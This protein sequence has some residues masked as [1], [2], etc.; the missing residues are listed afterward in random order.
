MPPV[1]FEDLNKVAKGVLIDDYS[2]TYGHEFKAKQKVDS[3]DAVVTTTVTLD[4]KKDGGKTASTPATVSLKLPKPFGVAGITIDKFEYN[5]TGDFKLESSFDKALLSVDGLTVDLKSNLVD[6]KAIS[7]GAT[8]T[9]IADTQL[10]FETK[11]FKQDFAFEATR[12]QGPA[13]L[14]LKCDQ[15][16]F[17]TPDLGLR[18]SQSG[19]FASLL[20]TG[21]FKTFE[22]HGHYAVTDA[23]DVAV[24]AKQEGKKGI[25]VT[26]GVAFQLNAETTIKA[27]VDEK[28]SVETITKYSPK[29]G[30]TFLLAGK[31]AG[32]EP[33]YGL[34]VNIE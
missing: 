17:Q 20:V 31:Y 4:A 25:S 14:G 30:L 5:K 19:V 23:L 6:T 18:I 27:K 2:K 15:S 28:G 9:G 10:K 21:G 32:G 16:N 1:K 8:F 7:T 26:A 34:A 33:G 13:T 29:K 3:I 11:P 22:A 12:I 24:N